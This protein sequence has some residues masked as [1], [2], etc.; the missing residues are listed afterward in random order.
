VV[1]G[2]QVLVLALPLAGKTAGPIEKKLMNVE[3]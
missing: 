1:E 3:H 2:S